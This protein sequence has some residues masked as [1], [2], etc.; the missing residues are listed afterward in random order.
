LNYEHFF[1]PDQI[2]RYFTEVR[3]GRRRLYDGNETLSF[4]SLAMAI[5]V[6]K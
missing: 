4:L 6:M 5:G 1:D 3:D 2:I